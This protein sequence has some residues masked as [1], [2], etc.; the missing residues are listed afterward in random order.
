MISVPTS[1][2]VATRVLTD[3]VDALPFFENMVEAD[4][5]L[6]TVAPLT[7]SVEAVSVLVVT[8]GRVTVDALSVETVKDVPVMVL[9]KI[10]EATR[11]FAD[12]VVSVSAGK[13]TVDA[14]RLDTVCCDT[15]RLTMYPFSE[16]SVFV[17]SVTE[18]RSDVA[19]VSIWPDGAYSTAVLNVMMRPVSEDSADVL[20]VSICPVA[21]L[22]NWPLRVEKR[23]DLADSVETDSV[24]TDSVDT[25]TVD[26]V[27][28]LRR[29]V[30]NVAAFAARLEMFTM[31]LLEVTPDSVETNSVSFA[32]MVWAT[33]S[34]VTMLPVETVEI[35]DV[36]LQVTVLNVRILPVSVLPV[37]VLTDSVLV[38]AVLTVRVLTR[39]VENV[40]AFAARLERLM[41]LLLA[42]TPDSVEMNSVSFAVMV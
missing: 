33:M 7:Y 6:A 36:E 9:P 29:S 5:V 4:S 13:L 14:V 38:S 1:N 19:S 16:L 22:M 23:V 20:S 42:V 17:L 21:L 37:R 24:E 39:S 41:M 3:S 31:L 28:E 18:L 2:V 40:A 32:V 10:V 34:A 27:S 25:D 26:T 15:S 11:L 8:D 12:R 30:E 35:L